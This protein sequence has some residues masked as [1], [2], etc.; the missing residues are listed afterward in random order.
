[1]SEENLKNENAADKTSAK[2]PAAKKR[3]PARAKK[4]K[5]A[6]ETGETAAREPR[7]E[8]THA[9]AAPTY[10]WSPS[11]TSGDATKGRRGSRPKREA[12]AA[13]NDEGDVPTK[14]SARPTDVDDVEARI[15]ALRQKEQEEENASGNFSE[16][17]K[18]NAGENGEQSNGGNGAEGTQTH[19]NENNEPSAEVGQQNYNT[20]S[21]QGGQQRGRGQWQDRRGGRDQRGGGRFNRFERGDRFNRNRPQNGGGNNNGNHRDHRNGGNANGNFQRDRQQERPQ[22]SQMQNMQQR[23]APDAAAPSV[24]YFSEPF[25]QW[26]ILNDIQS[27]ESKALEIA[28]SG[29]IFKLNELL[30]LGI[31]ELQEKAAKMEVTLESRAQRESILTKMIAKAFE[32]GLSI[33]AEG[34]VDRV[35]DESIVVFG[36]ENYRLK[37]IS[38]Y[39]PRVFVDRYNI[40]RGTSVKVQLHPA[41]VAVSGEGAPNNNNNNHQNSR[42]PIVLKVFTIAGEAPDANLAITPFEEL[43][44]FYPTKRILLE[45]HPDAKWDNFSM[46]IVDLLTPIGFGQRGLIVAPPRTGKTVLMQGIA[47]AI[48][49][50]HPDAHLMLLLVDERP[51]EVTDFKRQVKGEVVSSTFDETAHSHV[52]A[53]EIVIERARRMVERGHHVVILLDSI[54][55]LA[56]AY[57]ALMPSSG[58]I[59]SGGVESNALQKPKRFFG[60]ARNIENGGSLTI[61]GTALVDTGSKMDEVIFEE[62][63]GTG[64]MELHLDR[65]LV[66]KRLFPSIAIDKSGT[67]KEELLYHPDELLKIYGLRRAMKGVTPLEAMEML[68]AR[69]KKTKT[70]IEFLMGL[71]R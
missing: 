14:F 27:L 36:E 62:F 17:V 40:K 52:H 8:M 10:E 44:P 61:L 28:P 64:N 31:V 43:T 22:V 53:A 46:R 57:N 69:V 29:E 34:V 63:K 1:M 59:M 15:R 2:K 6:A 66:D 18:E 20:Q 68:I 54:T 5:P 21:N 41:R 70:N 55:R 30:S 60:S 50:N 35:G 38:P 16:G 47:N 48:A 51:E 13:Q 3:P 11:A 67:R 56:R 65:G 58:K 71:S 42:M 39:L 24:V 12:P 25:P 26:E 19:Q 37:S 49:E 4:E 32:K 23:N 9:E 33:Q 7:I 45:T